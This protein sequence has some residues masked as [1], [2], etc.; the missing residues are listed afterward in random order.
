MNIYTVTVVLG[1]RPEAIKLAP[2][3][4]EMQKPNSPLRPIVCVT[5]QHRHMLDQVLEWFRIKPDYDL[6]LMQANQG[7]AE[8]SARALTG[9][10]DLLACIRPHAVVVQG[11]TTTAAMAGLAAFY[12]RIPVAHVEA[13]LRTGDIYSP[14]PEEVNRR[15]IG[16]V[17]SF[18]FA[19][20]KMASGALLAERA[21]PKCVFTVGNTV[22][23]ALRLTVERR[24]EIQSA[25][26]LTESF[27]GSARSKRLI[28]VTAHR[29]E[30]F[31]PPFESICQAI[32]RLIE[33]NDDVE[34]VYPVHLNPNVRD[35]VSRI[36]QNV[37][38]IH[39]IEPVSYEQIVQLMLRSCLIL[40]DSGGIQEE[41][42]VLGRPTLVMRDTT[43]RPEAIAA[44]TAVLVGTDPDRIISTAE[45]LL[46]RNIQP[47]D[48]SRTQ[49]PFGDGFSAQRIVRIL[50]QHLAQPGENNSAADLRRHATV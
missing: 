1:T 13:G 47:T 27:D 14:F 37:P 16:V 48:S 18:H 25:I 50:A 15:L 23:D 5:G 36:L 43:E 44:G 10:S 12:Q 22:V 2:L 29:R 30:S 6:N 42:T 24:S 19:P 38:R 28:L 40:T 8:L 11:D 32:R 21:D 4:L 3:I 46:S 49:S 39:L 35:A 7:L 31:G 20:T 17:A 45:T 26:D 41:A 34:I 9:V 33:R